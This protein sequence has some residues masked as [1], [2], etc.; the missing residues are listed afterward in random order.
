MIFFAIAKL[1]ST[2]YISD[3]MVYD[4]FCGKKKGS[5]DKKREDDKTKR[6]I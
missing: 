4:L 2:I 6:K 3:L 5:R 1:I